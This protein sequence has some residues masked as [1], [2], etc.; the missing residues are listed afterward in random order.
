LKKIIVI[1]Y[2]VNPILLFEQ[3]SQAHIDV[4]LCRSLI[5]LIL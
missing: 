1:A 2:L 3:V 4:F 5:L